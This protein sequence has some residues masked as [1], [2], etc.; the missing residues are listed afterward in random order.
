MF[1]FRFVQARIVTMNVLTLGYSPCPNDT[2]MFY[3]LADGRVDC[4][5]L[6]FRER[7]ED[8]ETLNRLALRGELD[9]SKVSCHALGY[10]RDEYCVLRAGAALGRGCGPL[11]VARD[12]SGVDE[13]RGKRVALPGRFTTAALL[14]RLFCHDIAEP[15][16]LPFHMIMDAV[17]RGE[18]D[19][20]VIIHESRFT[21]ASHG[22]KM[23]M[24]LG[25]WWEHETGRPIPLGC[26]VARRSLGTALLSDLEEVLRDSIVYAN[27][28]PSEANGYIRGHSREMSDEVCTAHIGLYVNEFSLDLGCEGESALNALMER[29]Q[30]CGLIPKS[31]KKLIIK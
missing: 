14:F 3:A 4:R 6:A 13:L 24:D 7:L 18:V 2:H 8:V 20:G 23:I 1:W 31:S 28:R 15:V 5:G 21:Y 11:V 17:E 12:Y 29:A 27:E 26:V 25:D 16:F 10:L 30:S 22:L 19:A 9:V